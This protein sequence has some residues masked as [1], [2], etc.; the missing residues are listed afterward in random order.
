MAVIFEQRTSSLLVEFLIN[1]L[2]KTWRKQSLLYGIMNT[3][4]A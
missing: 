3:F 4:P 1:F 2:R